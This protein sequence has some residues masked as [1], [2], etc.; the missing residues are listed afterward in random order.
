MAH[1]ALCFRHDTVTTEAGL[2]AMS[3]VNH[4]SVLISALFDFQLER[5]S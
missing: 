2:W 3:Y 5:K 4:H 1:V